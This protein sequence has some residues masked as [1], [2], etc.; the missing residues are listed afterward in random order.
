MCCLNVS[1]GNDS[2]FCCWDCF[3]YREKELSNAF[4]KRLTSYK[5]IKLT[6]YVKCE[7]HDLVS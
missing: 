3:C 2:I 6:M 1:S 4:V 5:S 7:I